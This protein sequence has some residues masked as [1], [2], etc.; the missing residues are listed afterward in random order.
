MELEQRNYLSLISLINSLHY[1]YMELERK[2]RKFKGNSCILHYSYMEL[3]LS[4]CAFSLSF[5][6]YYIIP[7]WN[8]SINYL[9]WFVCINC[10]TL[11]LYGIGALYAGGIS[12]LKA[13]YII[14][15][16][17]WSKIHI[18]L[19]SNI[20]LITLFLYGIGAFN[21]FWF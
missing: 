13:N 5:N 15:I 21:F 11:F 19:L 14:P 8:W 9:T 16:W 10:I 12:V 3:E 2:K 6:D 7:I 1:S 4:L 18:Y 20:Q 17:N